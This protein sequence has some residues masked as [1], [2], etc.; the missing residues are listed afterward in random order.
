MP[1][2]APIGAL[3]GALLLLAWLGSAAAQVRIDPWQGADVAFVT[4]AGRLAVTAAGRGGDA[5]V[6]LLG[7]EDR[8]YQFPAWSPQGDRIAA[9]GS[10]ADDGAVQVFAADGSR[11]TLYA[12]GPTRAPFYLYWSP[13][14][15]TVS[16]LSGHPEG[17]IALRLA[18]TA[19]G[20]P[21]GAGNGERADGAA[22]E[23]FALGSPFYWQWTADGDRLLL[24][25][26]LAGP[27]ARFGF[28]DADA[29]TLAVNLDTPGFFQAPALSADGRFLAY[30]TLGSGG[31]RRLTVR[32]L[33][34]AGGIDEA[35]EV[36]QLNHQGLVALGWS[37]REPRLAFTAPPV[38]APH[39][40]GPLMLL[41][42][43]DGLL[44]EVDPGPVLGF[45]WS[46]DGRHL[47]YLTPRGRGGGAQAGAGA[48]LQR[49]VR[50]AQAGATLLRL[51]VVRV[52]VPSP[53]PR[54]LASFTPTPLFLTQF[55]PF[56]DQYALSHRLWSPAGDALVLPMLDE[57]RRSWVTVVDLSGRR[58]VLAEGDMPFWRTP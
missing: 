36:R 24:H 20:D 33:V 1:I 19:A 55:L 18:P 49:V 54:T 34:D 56:F 44:E 38:P 12:G 41:D 25:S 46:P 17:G 57:A 51:K 53:T 21:D 15:G 6:R 31:V 5:Q 29:D 16:F 50:P 11:R 4:P 35:G 14:G 43:R 30:G 45:F 48:E 23:P 40:F 2:R 8:R 47:A 32:P 42:A 7:D 27:R 28:S 13:D 58:Q 10:G 37:P 9:I 52:T 22:L 26:G 39:F 3:V